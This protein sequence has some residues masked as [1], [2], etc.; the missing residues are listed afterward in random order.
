MI[1]VLGLA[2]AVLAAV[3]VPGEDR[4]ARDRDA[5]LVRHPDIVDQS[6]DRRLGELRPGRV[7]VMAR[8][9]HEH[10]LVGQHQ[11]ERSPRGDDRER[12]ERRIQHESAADHLSV[13]VVP[14]ET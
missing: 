3:T 10:R 6:D 4:P 7:Q 14:G 9:V 12:L 13:L 1:D 8:S 2:A 5:G 11:D